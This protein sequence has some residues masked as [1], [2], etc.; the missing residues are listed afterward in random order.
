VS[1]EEYENICFKFT[2]CGGTSA[3]IET[4]GTLLPTV[5]VLKRLLQRY[6]L[7]EEW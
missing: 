1:F 6:N 2:I 5:Y 7:L 3:S 4:F